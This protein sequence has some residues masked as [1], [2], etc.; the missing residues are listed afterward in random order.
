[1]NCE[2]CNN[3]LIN[4]QKK[5]C[6][7]KCR[8]KWYYAND[9][10]TKVRKKKQAQKFYE[11][12]KNDPEYLRKRAARVKKWFKA[13]PEY[14]IKLNIACRDYMRRRAQFRK[15]NS[16]CMCCGGK[17]DSSFM[18]CNNCRQKWREYRK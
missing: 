12:H 3:K 11:Q 13:H 15:Q 17:R 18:N 10:K 16:L 1:M 6:S 5:Y 4:F 2:C 9:E 7:D 14:K 8:D